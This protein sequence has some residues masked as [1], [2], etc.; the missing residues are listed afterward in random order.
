[1]FA[2]NDPDNDAEALTTMRLFFRPEWVK[3]AIRGDTLED[4]AEIKIDS[5]NN[6]DATRNAGDNYADVALRLADT[7]ERFII[8]I[9]KQGIFE[10]VG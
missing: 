3:R 5:E 2:I 1:M 10:S 7:V 4:A 9:G 6:T 8:R